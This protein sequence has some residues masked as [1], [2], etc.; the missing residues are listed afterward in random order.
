MSVDAKNEVEQKPDLVN[1]TIDGVQVNVPKARPSWV[2][3]IRASA[4]AR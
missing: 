3:V 4:R 2:A 1:L